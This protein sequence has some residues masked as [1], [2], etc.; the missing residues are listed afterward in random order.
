MSHNTALGSPPFVASHYP[1]A[2][3]DAGAKTI[4]ITGSNFSPTCELSIPAALG[5]V[6]GPG[7]YTAVS[8]T[9][10]TVAFPVTT[11]AP[12]GSPTARICS[13]SNGGIAARGAAISVL[14]QEW[15]PDALVTTAADGWYVASDLALPDSTKTNSWPPHV[16][17]VTS[18][19]SEFWQPTTSNRPLYRTAVAGMG[20]EDVLLFGYEVGGVVGNYAFNDMYISPFAS[21]FTNLAATDTTTIAMCFRQT[22]YTHG[23]NSYYHENAMRFST[24]ESSVTQYRFKRSYSGQAS[25]ANPNALATQTAVTTATHGT[26]RVAGLTDTGLNRV[27]MTS[28]GAGDAAV[29]LDDGTP[30]VFS[31]GAETA[32]P[33]TAFIQGGSTWLAEIVILDYEIQ[34]SEI[35]LLDTYWLAKYG[36]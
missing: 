22:G 11:L 12:P 35:T 34:P 9:S 18:G 5:T 26:S 36:A 20:G 6:T 1:L 15:T 17:T 29:I 32:A 28:D 4:T 16:T 24:Y 3:V 23:S 19:L 25:W 13:L 7:V 27:V 2:F 14:H 21:T 33:T 30:V 10:G 8:G 31:V